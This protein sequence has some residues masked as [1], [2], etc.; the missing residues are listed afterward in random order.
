MVGSVHPCS[1]E[2]RMLPIGNNV[3]KHI[4]R[5]AWNMFH[6]SAE[7]FQIPRN[8]LRANVRALLA[9]CAASVNAWK[10]ILHERYTS[11]NLKQVLIVCDRKLNA[12]DME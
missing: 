3:G 10:Q 8:Q 11:L 2:L 6:F 12:E 4:Y 9:Q 7:L 5:L 1:Q